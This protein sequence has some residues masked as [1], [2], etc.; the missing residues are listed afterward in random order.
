MSSQPIDFEAQQ[1]RR[2]QR[3]AKWGAYEEDVLPLWVA[4]MDFTS[5]PAVMEALHRRVDHGIF[6][7]TMDCPVLFDTVAERMK[8]RYGWEINPKHIVAIPGMVVALNMVTQVVGKAG[9][10]VLMQT[11]VYGPFLTVPGNNGR[12]PVHVP[13][14]RV[15]DDAHT[16][17]YEIDFDLFEEAA[18]RQSSLFLLCNPH[19]PGGMA[20]SRAELERL[21][22]IC[23][24][25][26]VTICAD[27][28]HSDLLLDPDAKHIPIASLSPEIEAQTIT[29]I[30]PSKTYNLPGLGCSLAIIPNN[31]LREQYRRAVWGMGLHVNIMGYEAARA[32][33]QHGDE[34][35]SEVLAYIRANRDYALQR[36]REE[37]PQVSS[38]VPEATY[39]MWLDLSGLPLSDGQQAS[40]YLLKEAKVALNAGN[41][42]AAPEHYVRLNLACARST[43]ETALDRIRDTV[44]KLPTS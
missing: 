1:N 29:L 25:H 24:K 41:F 16:F 21:A 44:A 2:S 8:Q 13:L 42:F 6:G 26:N 34:W 31:E 7:Y 5:P 18:S 40:D 32:A 17:H 43:L 19:N 22:E 20:F 37:L 10:G 30:A 12:Y 35:L 11:P 23:L 3:S 15:D 9:D 36:L 28:I 27:E 4:D 33:Y 39:L 38:T 14:N